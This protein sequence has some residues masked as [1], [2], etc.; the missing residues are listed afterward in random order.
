MKIDTL[1]VQ[2]FIA[3]AEQGSFRKA[4]TTLHISQ[5]ALTR[6][7]Q[8][9]EA[10]LGITLVERTTRSV[11]LTTIGR[12][13]LPQAKRLLT[14]FSTTLTEL[15]ET[16]KAQR[17]DVCIACIPTAGVQF[18]PRIIQE[19]SARHPHNRIKI[20]DHLS[21]NVTEAVL[22]REAEFGINVSESHHPELTSTPLLQDQFVLV[23]RDD[24]P[25]ARNKKLPWRG[26]E[27]Y[28]VIFAAPVTANRSALDAAL[29]AR[30][31]GLQCFYEVQRSSTAIGMVAE[32]VAG[33]I[34][35]RL[36]IQKAAYPT[37]RV[38]G[39]IDPVVTRTLVLVKRKAAEL[40]PA[41]QALYDL[42]RKRAVAA[43]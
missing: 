11:E 26:L 42:T 34:V 21:P 23:C 2:A 12:N 3:I 22:R 32:G 15:R 24:H 10:A 7:L 39:L 31:F 27:P 43:A 13:F 16:G 40:S 4:G 5:T 41:T 28:P 8:N 35:P 33:A 25:L 29:G 19:Y 17:G 6:R 9:L 1:G 14:E 38:I 37:L 36:A 18:L 20:L 30:D